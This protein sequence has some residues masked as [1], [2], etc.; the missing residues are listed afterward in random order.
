LARCERALKDP[1]Q[2][3]RSVSEIAYGWGFS[4]MTRGFIHMSSK[5]FTRPLS[6]TKQNHL[7]S[8]SLKYRNAT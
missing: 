1:Q 7:Q 5:T 3:R 8:F 4:D 6:A 2:A